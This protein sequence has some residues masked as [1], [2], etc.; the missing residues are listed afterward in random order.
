MDLL[1]KIIYAD[2]IQLWEIFKEIEMI[3]RENSKDK[4]KLC[5]IINA[6]SG[7]CPEN[8]AFCAQSKHHKTN[9]NIFPLISP[10]DILKKAKEMEKAG[11]QRFSIVTSG[12]AISTKEDKEKVLKAVQLITEKTSLKCC[13]SLGIIDKD[14]MNDLKYTGLSGYHHNLETSRS[15]FPEI[16]STHNYEDDVKTV[17]LAKEE[18]FYVCSG[19][20]FGLGE[21]WEQRIEMA[22]TLKELEVD[23]LALNFLNPIKGTRLEGKNELTPLDCL[24]IIAVYRVIHKNRDIRICGGREINLK[25]LQPLI[26]AAGANGVMIGNYLTTK[27]REIPDDF[28]MIRELNLEMDSNG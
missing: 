27:G 15:F 22:E 8:C 6:K 16:C 24:K 10:E 23:S 21:T 9:I 19:G 2:R 3:K 13:A 14:F 28:E 18:G 25:Q 4:V 5:S 26:F 1:K 20:I 7:K 12:T 17:K 11:A